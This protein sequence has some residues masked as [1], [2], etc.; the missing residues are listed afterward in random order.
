MKE[1]NCAFR[2][3]APSHFKS[4]QADTAHPSFTSVLLPCYPMDSSAFLPTPLSLTILHIS[5]VQQKSYDKILPNQVR[6]EGAVEQIQREN[7]RKK[8]SQ[9]L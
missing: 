9:Y 6:R 4:Q 5:L 2:P 1:E 8:E 7:F 3:Q